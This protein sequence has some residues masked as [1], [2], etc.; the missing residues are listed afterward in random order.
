[1][2]TMEPTQTTQVTPRPRRPKAIV[3]LAV[4]IVFVAGAAIAIWAV[5]ND[6]GPVAAEDA[7]LELTFTGD[8]ASYVGDREIIEGLAELVFINDGTQ[9]VWFVVQYFEPGSA[10]LESELDRG[11]DFFTNGTPPGATPIFEQHDPGRTIR[12]IL[13][14]PGTYV[15]QAADA[16]GDSTHVWQPGI[17]EVSSD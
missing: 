3:A 4:A 7:R 2:Q 6:G 17:V 16:S 15:L 12:S 5:T 11:T 9:P 10:A 13:L 8:D 14:E 1:M